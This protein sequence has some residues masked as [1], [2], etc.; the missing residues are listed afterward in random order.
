[1]LV[2]IR[3]KAAHTDQDA[4]VFATRTGAAP[5]GD[6]IRSRV[7]SVA[8]EHANKRVGKADLPP[9]PDKLTPHSLRRTFCSLCCTRSARIPAS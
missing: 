3:A 5:S 2:G 1:V 9:L 8:V 6:N 4:Y 7:L